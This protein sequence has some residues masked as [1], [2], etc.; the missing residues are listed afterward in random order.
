MPIQAEITQLLGK[1]SRGDKGAKDKLFELVY[2]ELRRRA[3]AYLRRERRGHTLQ[4]TDL[5]HEAYFKLVDQ[6][7]VQWQDRA[8]FFHIAA[9][10]MRRILVD[11]AR[12]HRALK[13]GGGQIKISIEDDSTIVA[14]E[15]PDELIAVDAALEKLAVMDERQSEIVELRF[16]GGHTIEQTAEILAISVAT[17]KREWRPA[18]AW[19][20]REIKQQLA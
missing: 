19:L 12:K 16:F 6:K 14:E 18:K 5:V 9:K 7:K 8:H 3:S 1:M 2:S 20:A 15:R 4:T 13:R 10:V 17:V 11:H